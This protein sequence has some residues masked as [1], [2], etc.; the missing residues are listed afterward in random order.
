[1]TVLL[2]GIGLVLVF[3]GLVF[4]LAPSRLEELIKVIA[5]TPIETR[6][7]IGLAAV[8]LGVLLVWVSGAI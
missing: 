5:E 1:M 2:L 6:R 7:A 8:A 4:A 3:E